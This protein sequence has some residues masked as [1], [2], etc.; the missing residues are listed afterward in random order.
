MVPDTNIIWKAEGQHSK[1]LFF[2]FFL[3]S[4]LQIWSYPEMHFTPSMTQKKM[5]H[6]LRVTLRGKPSSKDE[7][8]YEDGSLYVSGV[9]KMPQRQYGHFD[10]LNQKLKGMRESRSV[11][12]Q[13]CCKLGSTAFT[14]QRHSLETSDYTEHQEK[15]LLGKQIPVEEPD[16]IFTAL[17]KIN[18][19]YLLPITELV[20]L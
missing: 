20:R 15:Q 19:R 1:L 8:K 16:T 7:N 4:Y 9:K 13:E 11:S 12:Q 3:A 5:H 14:T 6:F 2:F 17:Y 10:N 18:T